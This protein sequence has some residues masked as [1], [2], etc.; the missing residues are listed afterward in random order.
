MARTMLNEA[1]I[2]DTFWREVV[3]T[4]IYILSRAQIR[5]NMNKKTYELWKGRLST[6]K[7]FRLF[8]RN[9]Y[10]KRNECNLGKF[11]SRIY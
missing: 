5:V 8:G 1:K 2:P 11:H 3:S 7:Q 4:T 9:F 6:F 10:V